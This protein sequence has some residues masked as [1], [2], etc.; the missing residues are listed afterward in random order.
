VTDFL[1][2]RQ[3]ADAATLIVL[4]V[5][6][7]AVVP[8]NLVIGGLPLSITPATVVGLGIALCWACAHLVR[9]SGMA[10]GHNPVRTAL[11]VLVVAQLMAYAHAMYRYT[12]GDEIRLAD[13]T[14]VYVL[15][16]VGTALMICDGVRDVRRLEMVLRAV[17]VGC[18]FVAMVGALQFTVG[19]DLAQHLRLPGLRSTA[20]YGYVTQRGGFRRPAGTTGTPIEFGVLCAMALPIALH[21][22][23]RANAQ[24]QGRFVWW[25]CSAAIAAGA[26]Y[27]VSRSAILG[28][29]TVGITLFFGWPAKRQMQAL[30]AVVVF[31]VAIRL[32]AKNLIG[33]IYSLFDG[34]S[35]D[36]S[37]AYRIHDYPIAKQLIAQNPWLGTGWG[38]HYAPKHIVFDNQYLLTLV[39]G[40][41][42]GLVGFI[43]LFVTTMAI[44]L[45][46]RFRSTD[47]V[48]RDLALSLLA[49]LTVPA[50]GA[51][52]FDLLSFKTVTGLM[53]VLIGAVAALVR[54]PDAAPRQRRTPE[55]V[56]PEVVPSLDR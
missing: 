30:L 51:I 41:V 28:L 55:V 46:S 43:A 9:S 22:G 10:K 52:T 29:T 23:F 44:A 54:I 20:D 35:S 5:A 27:S 42:V 48:R 40:G 25:A 24:K 47:P 37:I 26:V 11:F 53:M 38:T 31:I 45:R 6:V 21:F 39:E 14:V 13:Q 4:Y 2:A 50:V 49:A 56:T 17:V 8:A 18:A 7:L 33:T 19:F 36:S 1:P 32:T 15:V 16:I 3:P 34:L 12:P